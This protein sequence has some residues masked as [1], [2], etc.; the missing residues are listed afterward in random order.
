MGDWSYSNHTLTSGLS[1]GTYVPKKRY[2]ITALLYRAI[3]AGW[4]RIGCSTTNPNLEAY[5]FT[6]GTSGLSVVGYNSSASSQSV[7]VGLA[8]LPVVES[9]YHRETSS[10]ADRVTVDT[11][12]VTDQQFSTTIG[13]ESFFVLTTVSATGSVSGTP[14]PVASATPTTTPIASL[15]AT[16][17]PSPT[18]TPTAT[19][20]VLLGDTRV[21]STQ[22][23]NSAGMAEAFLTTAVASGT[24]DTLVVYVDTGSTATQLVAG[25]YTDNGSGTRP[26][27]LLA[28]GSVMSPRAGAWKDVAIG[29]TMLSAGTRCPECDANWYP[30]A[31]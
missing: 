20:L 27:A 28:Q 22:D 14:A 11:P 4:Q 31:C 24:T 7:T 18:R 1:D 9:V 23:W 15:T 25:L 16:V 8:N 30:G 21:E 3:P 12:T 10:T 5:C 26:A 13:S 17:T 2:Q 29:P 19:P 6:D